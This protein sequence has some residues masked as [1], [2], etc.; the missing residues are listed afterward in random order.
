MRSLRYFISAAAMGGML[1]LSNTVWA[2]PVTAT[3]HTVGFATP[4]IADDLIHIHGW[5]CT[6]KKGWYKGEKV[7][8]RHRRACYENYDDDY[9]YDDDYRSYP[10]RTSPGVYINPGAGIRLHLGG[11]GDWD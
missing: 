11:Q 7:W 8:H 1:V 9:D 5:H 4:L 3:L 10:Y 6:K 2:N